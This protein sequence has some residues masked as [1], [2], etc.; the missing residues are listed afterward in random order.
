M[1]LVQ[2]ARHFFTGATSL[3]FTVTGLLHLATGIPLTVAFAPVT[4]LSCAMLWA[5]TATAIKEIRRYA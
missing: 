5:L 1:L 2:L 3:N 4:I